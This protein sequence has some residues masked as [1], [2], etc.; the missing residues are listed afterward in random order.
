MVILTSTL[1]C[2]FR[3]RP[4]IKYLGKYVTPELIS[5]PMC[6][7]CDVRDGFYEMV[8]E[9]DE[10]LQKVRRPLLVAVMGCEVNGPGEARHADIGIAFGKK[11]GAL[12]KKGDILRTLPRDEC[13]P[14]LL[15]E[16]ARTW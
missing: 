2:P 3:E 7:R 13:I 5:C 14:A 4:I 6:G 10:A 16:I 12:F 1:T 15:E 9:V 11:R 8:Q